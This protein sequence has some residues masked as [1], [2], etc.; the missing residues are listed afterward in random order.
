METKAI[1]HEILIMHH[2]RFFS[3][4]FSKKANDTN[5]KHF[6]IAEHLAEACWNGLINETLPEIST[7]LSLIK[8]NEG[9]YFLDLQYGNY[10]EMERESSLNPYLFLFSQQNN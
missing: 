7:S 4:G 9:S 1:T 3:K 10:D 6:T 8:I 2:S 5:D